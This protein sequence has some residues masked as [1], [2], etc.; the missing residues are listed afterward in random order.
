MVASA[1][2]RHKTDK[3]PRFVQNPAY[4]GPK[5]RHGRCGVGRQ[6]GGGL[7][8]RGRGPGGEGKRASSRALS[9]S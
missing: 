3:A 8:T 5:A 1:V 6:A 9:H 2:A 7:Q 4:W